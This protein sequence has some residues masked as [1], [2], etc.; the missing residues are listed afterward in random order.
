MVEYAILVA[1]NTAGSFNLL[2]GEVSS[3]LSRLSW[4]AVVYAVLALAT[5]RI[6]LGSFARSR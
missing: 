5:L 4:S 3:L 1:H 6:L 2:S